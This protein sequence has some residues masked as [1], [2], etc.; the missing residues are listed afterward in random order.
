[1]KSRKVSVVKMRRVRVRIVGDKIREVKRRSVGYFCWI[2]FIRIL[3]FIV[4][5]IRGEWGILSKRVI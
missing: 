2:D 3:V 5:D 4:S 1:M